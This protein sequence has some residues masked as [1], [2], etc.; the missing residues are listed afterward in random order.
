MLQI[1][2]FIIRVNLMPPKLS[3]RRRSLLVCIIHSMATN[4]RSAYSE[5]LRGH[6]S[7]LGSKH[8][9]GFIVTNNDAMIFYIY[10]KQDLNGYLRSEAGGGHQ[11]RSGYLGRGGEIW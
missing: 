10:V 3:L 6:G 1:M 9:S 7:P 5:K 8:M 2:S 11:S 4:F